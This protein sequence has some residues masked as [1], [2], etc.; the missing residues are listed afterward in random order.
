MQTY[1]K[2]NT[3]IEYCV[4]SHKN[5][6]G[7]VERKA[8]SAM[9]HLIFHPIK[10]SNSHSTLHSKK[11]INVLISHLSFE[12][13]DSLPKDSRYAEWYGLSTPEMRIDIVNDTLRDLGWYLNTNDL[14][15]DEVVCVE[16]LGITASAYYHADNSYRWFCAYVQGVE[17]LSQDFR[18]LNPETVG[19]F[20]RKFNIDVLYV[21]Q[22]LH[23]AKI[24]GAK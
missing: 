6:F 23:R 3:L 1:T 16:Y 21:L 11:P 19:N 18:G 24:G 14:F 10:Y 22:D 2:A 5:L 9:G 15:N 4:L 8:V 17:V 20:C 13:S 7:F 12:L